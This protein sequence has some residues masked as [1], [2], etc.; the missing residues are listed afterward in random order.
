MS[1]MRLVRREP[2]LVAVAGLGLVMIAVL[3][4]ML[5]QRADALPPPPLSYTDGTIEADG[6]LLYACH[7]DTTPACDALAPGDVIH[8]TS[9]LNVPRRTSLS[10]FLSLWSDDCNRSVVVAENLRL[11]TVP[12]PTPRLKLSNTYTLPDT[13]VPG[14]YRLIRQTG[15]VGSDTTSYDVLFT[16][17]G[18]V[19][20]CPTL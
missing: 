9:V 12:H 6:V 20:A 7:T 1:P 5:A 4:L 16:V 11:L 17:A 3:S 15:G 13:L 2:Y 8:W 19:P 18:E 10:T 14:H